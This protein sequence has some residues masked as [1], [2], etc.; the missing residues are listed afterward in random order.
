MV[1]HS[2]GCGLLARLLGPPS[3]Q[4]LCFLL[5]KKKGG[6][7]SGG[8]RR[9]RRRGEGRNGT[10]AG[11][12]MAAVDDKA[13]TDLVSPLLRRFVVALRDDVTDA[14]CGCNGNACRRRWRRR[15]CCAG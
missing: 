13:M 15:K 7:I 14:Q 4:L 8:R 1:H 9:R 11:A 10:S 3:P 12:E 6:H 2:N 5:R